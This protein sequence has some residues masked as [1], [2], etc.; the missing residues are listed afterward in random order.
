MSSSE[1]PQVDHRRFQEAL[2]ASSKVAAE[3]LGDVHAA[4]AA[5]WLQDVTDE[6][7]WEVFALLSTEDQ[8]DLLEHAEDGL[9]RELV[10]RMSSKGL[11]EVV[12]ELPSDKAVDVL[13]EAGERVTAD[14]LGSVSRETAEDLRALISHNPESAGG[15]MT[16]EFV[17]AR[18][19]DRIGDVVKEIKKEGEDSEENLGVFVVDKAGTPVGYL[20][21]RDLLTHSIHDSVS[22]LMAEPFVIA[23]DEDQEAAATMIAKYALS[24]LAVVDEAGV[25]VGVI[26]LDDAQVI[27]EEEATEDV[28]RLVGTSPTQQTRLPILVRASQRL[29]LMGITVAGGLASAQILSAFLGPGTQSPIN[30]AILRYLP[31]IVG[32]AGN[33]GVQT[34]TILVRGFATGEVERNREREVFVSEVAVGALIGLLCGV[35]TFLFAAWME[36]SLEEGVAIG[37]S[38]GTAVVAAVTWAGALGGAV[39]MLCRRMDID[40]AVVA[41]AFLISLSDISGVAIYMVVADQLLSTLGQG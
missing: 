40:P 5:T 18:D 27:L 36:G 1:Q 35:V 39:P 30:E 15:V 28:H 14:I 10:T 29:P 33:V 4:D 21:D 31:L 37:L 6:Q 16:T 32:L 34:S 8:A 3:V 25:L 2:E 41:G 19:D 13:A 23:A 12:E 22:D 7:A 9:A 11:R 38:V 17:L 26:S 20:S 24:A